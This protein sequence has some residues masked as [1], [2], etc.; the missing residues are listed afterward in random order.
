MRRRSSRATEPP[1]ALTEAAGTTPAGEPAPTG[2]SKSPIGPEVRRAILAAIEAAW[3][4]LTVTAVADDGIRI[5]LPRPFVSPNRGAFGGDQ[6]Y[7]DTYFTILGLIAAGRS[8]L[9]RGMVDNLV[10]LFE[11]FGIVPSRNRFYNLGIS[12]PPFLTSMARA[13]HEADGDDA[14]LDRVMAIAARECDEYWCDDR[15]VERHLAARGLSRYVD[16][17]LLDA[18]SEHESGWDTT[19]RFGGRCL[20]YLPVDLNALLYRYESDLAWHAERRGDGSASGA[21]A[22]RA[23]ARRSTMVEL[24][25]NERAGFWFDF[26]HVRGRRS[27]FWSLAG[28]YPLWAGMVDA[29]M[30]ARMR[31]ALRRFEAEGG[32]A[33]T[34]AQSLMKPFR[35]W[36]APN[37]W[38]NQHV[39]VVRALDAAGYAADA[40]RIA[41]KYLGTIDRVFVATGELW[42][43]YDVV[44]RTI[45]RAGAYPTQRGFAWTNAAY[46]E[47]SRLLSTQS[48]L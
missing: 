9:A 13:V 38:P 4:K 28:F 30:A 35:Q 40:R 37:G 44:S 15:R 7:W 3:E 20:S 17:Y 27:H 2:E 47:L 33:N 18:T 14:W 34:Q 19:S 6:F 22:A 48:H 29:A 16:H 36:D 45:G 12:Q 39:L 32:L 24:M 11:R 41:V 31:E 21:W 10:Y 43:K 42:E 26:D 46:L 5:G 8:G 23:A 25:W 1:E